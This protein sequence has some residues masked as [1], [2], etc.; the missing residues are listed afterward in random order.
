MIAHIDANRDRF[1]VEPI[2]QLL[3]IA[4]STYHAARHRPPSARRR[5]DEEL[6]AVISRVHAEHFGVYGARKVWRQLHR[7]GTTVARCT[8]ERLL[9]EL[10]LQGVRR[11][12]PRRTTTPDA[13][14]ARPADLVERD[15][16]AARPNQLWVADL[17]YVATWSGFV[18]VA[19]VIDAF[20]RFLVGWQASRSLRTDLALDALE[21]AIWRRQA[22]LDGL[23]HHSDR[24]SQYLSIRY[25]E[26]LAEAGAVASV[27]SVGDSYDNA[28][29]ETIIGLYKTE[30]IR[31]RG[32]WK[33]L[34]DVEYATL[35]W[36]D[37]FNHRRLLEPIGHLPPAEF[38]AA[39]QRE[40]DSSSPARL[41]QPSLR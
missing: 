25:T 31:R 37:W 10:G 19:L 26:R 29:A 24:G 27:G 22:Q 16:S 11:G 4:P 34:D 7:E 40:E 38:E 3:P 23:V 32:P 14:A 41:K 36:V 28:L 8:V 21:M 35:E 5:R 30:L 2:C 17:T 18:Y 15:F 9:R 39:F 13:A 12:K 33:G 6:K 1:G 20:S